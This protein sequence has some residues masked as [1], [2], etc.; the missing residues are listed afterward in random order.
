MQHS[1]QTTSFLSTRCSQ[2]TVSSNMQWV[3][4]LLHNN[5]PPNLAA[6]LNILGLQ[7]TPA[8]TMLA[9]LEPTGYAS[10]R[11]PDYR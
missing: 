6:F 10:H 4:L 9:K 2:D 8:S 1:G 11:N 5:L 7:P 3:S